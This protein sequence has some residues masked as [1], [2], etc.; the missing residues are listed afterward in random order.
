MV[1]WC[2]TATG[3][4]AGIEWGPPDATAPPQVTEVIARRYACQVCGAVLLVVP[5]GVQRRRLYS[6]PA[7]ALALAVWSLEQQTPAAV[8]ARVSPWRIVGA[9][10]ATR[11]T[12]LRR[13]AK[14]IRA[15][16]LFPEVR[17]APDGACLRAIAARAAT[18]LAALAPSV[19]DGLPLATRAFLGAAHVS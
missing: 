18:T 19:A 2:C 10:A 15:G 7:V 9:A 3:S 13:W 16:Q 5:S 6:A 4:G 14:A 17:A 12:S 1:A 11:W 8:R